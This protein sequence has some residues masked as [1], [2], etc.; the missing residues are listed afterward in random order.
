MASSVGNWLSL[1]PA[2]PIVLISKQEGRDKSMLENILARPKPM[3]PNFFPFIFADILM[4][5]VSYDKSHFGSIRF[6]Q[7]SEKQNEMRC[8][9]EE[10]ANKCNYVVHRLVVLSTAFIDKIGCRRSDQSVCDIIAG[11]CESC[12]MNVRQ[13][14]V[15]Y[16]YYLSACDVGVNI[17]TKPA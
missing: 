17:V 3:G 7:L 1:L 9:L 8:L 12:T 13:P 5:I 15:G 6:S 16:Y 14:L 11:F 10:I 2:K 4:S